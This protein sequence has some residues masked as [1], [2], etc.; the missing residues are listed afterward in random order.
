MTMDLMVTESGAGEA[1]VVFVHGVLDRGRSFS[2][3]G[4]IL[5]PECRMLWYD[6]RGYGDSADAPG[7]PADIDIHIDDVVTV[8]DGRPAVVVG[9]SFGGVI[10]AGAAVRAPET[11][12][13]LVL[14]ES[15]M[16]WA[17]EWDDRRLRQ[18]LWGVEPEEA[19]LRLMLGDRYDSLSAEARARL[20]PQARAFIQEERSARGVVPPY[21]AADLRVPVVYGFS[22]GFPVDGMRRHLSARVP[23]VEF[24]T[25]SADH[26]AHRSAPEAFAGLIRHG[27]RRR[28]VALA[29]FQVSLCFQ[30]GPAQFGQHPRVRGVP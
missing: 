17:P 13:A 23:G 6:R 3:V 25:I 11:V 30:V 28:A 10:A 29:V 14:Y 9:H 12:Q 5:S 7:V 16:G 18:L 24:A 8:L 21:D 4:E 2:R 22:D 20:L 15:V 27:L 19:G 1:L 26:N